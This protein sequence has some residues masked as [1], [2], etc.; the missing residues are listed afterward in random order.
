[1]GILSDTQIR[2]FVGIEPFAENVKRPG[3]VS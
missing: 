3:R 2:E 1:M